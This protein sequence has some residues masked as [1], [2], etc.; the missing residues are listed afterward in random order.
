MVRFSYDDRSTGGVNVGGLSTPE[1]GFVV[2][3]QDITLAASLTTIVS[4]STVFE[5]RF[6]A[7]DS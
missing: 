3:E 6:S 4:P 2:D 1:A 5:M 7:S